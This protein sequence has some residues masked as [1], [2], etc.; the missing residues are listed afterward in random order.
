MIKTIMDIQIS[1]EHFCEL[2]KKRCKDPRLKFTNED[3]EIIINSYND[4]FIYANTL[5]Q[6]A[7]KIKN[8]LMMEPY[9]MSYYD[10]LDT[11]EKAINPIMTKVHR[12]A[13][14]IWRGKKETASLIDKEETL[15]RTSHSQFFDGDLD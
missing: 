4:G 13:G 3:I 14:L 8:I 7:R 15:M 5:K 12:E 6:E 2:L 1:F 9:I 11:L 10:E